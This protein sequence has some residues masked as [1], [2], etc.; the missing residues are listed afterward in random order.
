MA[1]AQR[2]GGEMPQGSQL[3]LFGLIRESLK[4]TRAPAYV[5]F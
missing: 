1:L 4:G 5:G 2:R 3:V